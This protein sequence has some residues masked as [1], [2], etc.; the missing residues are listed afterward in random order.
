MSKHTRIFSILSAFVVLAVLAA[1][2]GLLGPSESEERGTKDAAPSSATAVP[3][4]DVRPARSGKSETELTVWYFDKESME[5]AL[6]KFQ[7]KYPNVQVNFVQQPFGDMSKKYQ[8]ALAARANVPDVIGLDTSM[9]GRFLDAGENL[10]AA[11]YNAGQFEQ[12]FVEWKFNAARTDDG[13]MPVFPWDV[14]TGVMFYRPDVFEQAGLPTDPA[15]VAKKLA[16]W[17]DFIKAGQQI[18]ERSGGKSSIVGNAKDV[19]NAAY[20]QNGGNIVKGKD[21]AFVSEGMEPLKLAIRA[22]QAGIAPDP[23]IATWS[24]RWAPSLKSGQIATV[25]MGA[26]MMGNLK[27][28]I[29]KEG[30]GHWRV[31]AAPGGAFNNGGT[32]LQVPALAQ[33]KQLAWEFVKFLTTTPEVQNAIFQKTGIVPAYKPAWQSGV[34]DQA[35]PFLGNQKPW[36][37]IIDLAQ[38]VKPYAY[39]PVDALGTD[40]LTAQVDLAIAG[41]LAPDQALRAAAQQLQE[42]AARVAD[43]RLDVPRT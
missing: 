30:A 26:W 25:T 32:Y 37:L 8:A 23:L 9:V 19:F 33:N 41:K 34:Y 14:A 35:E 40:L 38:Q 17:E 1:G 22:Q 43:L 18:K 24:E 42:R 5:V 6:S 11:P 28:W 21:V 31:T 10:A 36:R 12:D 16:T 7:E 13:K 2:C 39:S 27:T 29:D 3:N 15:E 20:W 4:A